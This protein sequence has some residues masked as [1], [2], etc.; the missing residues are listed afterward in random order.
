MARITATDITDELI[1][2]VVA[3]DES[4]LTECDAYLD[5]LARSKGSLLDYY[6]KTGE[7]TIED[8]PEPMPYKVK[9]LA[10]MWVCREVCARKSGSGGAA[11]RGQESG[12][13][14]SSKL[15]YFARQF[16]ILEGQIAP[17]V[18]LGIVTSR[19][20]GQITLERA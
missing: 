6:L 5:D 17:E 11:F 1:K 8:I 10:V 20:V 9:R 3:A 4:I 19:S 14:W 16:E 15:S 7:Y 18:L 12:D 13:K 2:P